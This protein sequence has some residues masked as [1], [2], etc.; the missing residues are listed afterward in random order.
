MPS[1]IDAGALAVRRNLVIVRAGDS[2]LHPR[3]L[4]G[5]ENRAWDLVVSYFGDDAE[6]YLRPDVQRVD[7]KGTKWPA[8]GV[9]LENNRELISQYDFVWLPDDDID[10]KS[11][12]IDRMFKVA[13]QEDLSLCQPSLAPD[14]YFS[15][16]IT[17]TI[18]FF[19]LRYTNFVEAMVPCFRRDLL[20][21]CVPT[22]SDTMSGW[23]LEYVW[24]A[25]ANTS[26]GRVAI[27]DAVTVVHTRPV[28]GPNYRLIEER[29]ISPRE[30]MRATLQKYE[31]HSTDQR[32]REAITFVSNRSRAGDSLLVRILTM[33]AF[34]F[35]VIRGYVLRRPNRRHLRRRLRRAFINLAW[36]KQSF[37]A[38]PGL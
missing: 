36:Q 37:R 17:L 13:E 15:F 11:N 10:C 31:I 1:N 19:K 12:D 23:G 28:G 27:I 24:S 21:E 2:S 16:P 5:G 8:L 6:R 25:L 7:S 26:G 14:S 4:Q 33:R 30:E 3:W 34:A 9:F 38:G 22:M 20:L 35:F 29:G 32:V 18:P